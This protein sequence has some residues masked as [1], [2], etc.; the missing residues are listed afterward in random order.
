VAFDDMVKREKTLDNPWT[1][2]HLKRFQA[3]I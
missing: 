2:W 3:M 1:D